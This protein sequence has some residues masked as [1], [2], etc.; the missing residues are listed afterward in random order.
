MLACYLPDPFAMAGIYR[1]SSR[2][3]Q[4]AFG[5]LQFLESLSPPMPSR[6]ESGSPLS[7]IVSGIVDRG[8]DMAEMVFVKFVFPHLSHYCIFIHRSAR[9]GRNF[10]I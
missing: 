9:Q 6:G 2:F 3:S 5:W 7:K 8:G 10:L 1:S 4:A